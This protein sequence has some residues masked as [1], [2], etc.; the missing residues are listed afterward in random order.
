MKKITVGEIEQAIGGRLLCGDRETTALEICT[1]SRKAQGGAAFFALIGE[2]LDAHDFLEQVAQKGCAIAIVSQEVMLIENTILVPDTT[3]ALQDLA[4]WYLSTFDIK[5][6]GITGSTGK[7]TTKDMMYYILSEKYKTG[8]NIGNFNNLIGLPLTA[9][10]FEEGTEVAVFEM[11]TDHLGEIH[12][13]AEI[14]KPNIG[15]ITNIGISHIQTIGSRE[16]ILQAKLEITDFFSETDTL[17]INEE[18]DLLTREA[19]LGNYKL[20]TVGNNGKSNYIISDISDFGENGIE[21]TLEHEH[22]AQRF[23]LPIPGRHNAYNGAVAVAAAALL[24]VSMEEAAKGLSKMIL[25]EKRLSIKGKDGIKV[26]DD[27]YNASPPAVK[28]A[29]DVL[30]ATRGMR[31]VAVLGDMLGL[32]EGSEKYHEEVGEYAAKCGV[33]L[34]IGIGEETKFIAEAAEKSLGKNQ[35]KYFE[36]KD[37]FFKKMGTIIAR[38]DVILVKGSRGMAMEQVVKKILE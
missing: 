16:K 32:G 31:K 2:N 9:L 30:I 13:L 37:E 35:V 11:G 20:I 33:D 14:V 10:S 38:G 28:A 26:I 6:I 17:I 3:K 15:I 5:K 8:R 27:T 4:K 22:H 18:N 34:V 23:K 7:T 36:T 25:T 29:I 19:A 21:F 24:G 1:D 12:T